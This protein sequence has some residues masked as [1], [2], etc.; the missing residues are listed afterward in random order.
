M[1]W[2]VL[3]DYVEHIGII[4][5]NG[6]IGATRAAFKEG[7][8]EDGEVWMEMVKTRNST[9][10]SY[11]EDNAAKSSKAI[12]QLYFPAFKKLVKTLT[13]RYDAE[14]LGE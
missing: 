5:V 1:A 2:N 4:G 12:I 7:V 14:D 8:I 13:A 9:V 6:S 3:K 11:D 10:H